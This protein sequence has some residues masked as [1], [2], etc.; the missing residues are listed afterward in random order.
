MGNP[1]PEETQVLAERQAAGWVSQDIATPHNALTG[2]QSGHPAEYMVFSRDLSL[3]LIDQQGDD[4]TPLSPEVTEKTVYLRHD[5]TCEATPMTCYEPLVSENNVPS[6]TKFGNKFGFEGATPDLTHIVLASGVALTSTSAPEGGLYEWT[7]GHLQLVSVLPER[8]ESEG[9]TP[10]VSPVLGHEVNARHAISNNG[11][12]IFWSAEGHLYMRD[13]VTEETV[14][15]DANQGGPLPGPEPRE[16]Q[17]QTASSEGSRVFFTDA[18][19]LTEHSTAKSEYPPAPDLYEYD[20]ESGKLTDLAVDP[21]TGESA[22]VQ[23]LVIG[24]SEDGSSVYFVAN[25]ALASGAAPGDCV[26]EA[27][28]A[29]A[30][31]GA[32]CNLY[33]EHYNGTKWTPATFIASLS[34]QDERDWGSASEPDLGKVTSRVS[35]DGR[36]LAFMSERSLTGYDNIDANGGVPDEE[37]FLYDATRPVSPGNP[38][39]ASCDPTGARPVGVFDSGEAPGL[40]VDRRGAWGGHWLAGSIPK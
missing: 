5:A 37:V 40:L 3:G 33:V 28:G 23:G 1:A 2:V 38:V 16:A 21:N 13:M 35:P 22:D 12:R 18:E 30:P 8:P 29:T 25:G 36:Y 20:V 11:S 26:N 10:A 24:A 19:R 4:E 31:P 6:G 7:G 34:N 27:G 39:C 14:Q 32:T 15:I 17:F 9:G